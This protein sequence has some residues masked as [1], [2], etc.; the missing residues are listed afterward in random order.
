MTPTGVPNM[1][2]NRTAVPIGSTDASCTENQGP[3]D[4][5]VV[6]IALRRDVD[7]RVLRVG[8]RR[9]ERATRFAVDKRPR[10]FPFDSVDLDDPA[11]CVAV[12]LVDRVGHEPPPADPPTREQ[13]GVGFEID[14]RCAQTLGPRQLLGGAPTGEHRAHKQHP[15]HSS[16]PSTRRHPAYPFGWALNHFQA[17]PMISSR[18]VIWADHPSSLLIFAGF[19]N[20][21]G[22]SPGRRVDDLA[23]A[24]AV[25]DAEVVEPL[26]ARL[27]RVH[28]RDVGRNERSHTCT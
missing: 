14:D 7:E 12:R 1:P 25:A 3:L 5:G 4:P 22:G 6:R 18:S 13:L 8:D 9:S 21:F 27:E 16:S 26:I 24:H 17:E 28:H 23:H 15:H 11:Q 2:G 20:S 10:A 19:A